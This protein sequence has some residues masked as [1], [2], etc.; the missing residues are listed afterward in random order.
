MTEKRNN[1]TD[2]DKSILNRIKDQ[3][4]YMFSPAKSNKATKDLLSQKA[5]NLGD[6]SKFR[7]LK[8]GAK[9][10]EVKKIK[11][12]EENKN[13]ES[14]IFSETWSNVSENIEVKKTELEKLKSDNFELRAKITKLE[15]I[16][17]L[18]KA[19]INEYEKYLGGKD[20]PSEINSSIAN[21][22]LS[23]KLERIKGYT[24]TLS[25]DL[26]NKNEDLNQMKETF[27]NQLTKLKEE[28]DKLTNC[29]SALE[30]SSQLLVLDNEELKRIIKKK[31]EEIIELAT[32]ISVFANDK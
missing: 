23:S 9:D 16:S 4:V 20:D 17:N 1:N 31:C 6:K 7:D 15:E 32:I 26:N 3:V 27:E 12:Q 22:E 21:L 2:N 8:E 18:E 5:E 28:N 25:T 24:K 30:R 13:N 10:I 14:V 11:V 29:I 19:R